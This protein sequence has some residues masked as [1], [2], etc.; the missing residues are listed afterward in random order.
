MHAQHIVEVR[1]KKM[2]SMSQQ[3]VEL[4]ESSQAQ[5][6]ELCVLREAGQST[7]EMREEFA[8]R[9]GMSEKKLQ[10]VIKVS[11]HLWRHQPDVLPHTRRG[12][13]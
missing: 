3:I 6:D 8:K 2:M 4:M 10:A 9:I 7:A 13:A 5:Q 1:E 11:G 12:T